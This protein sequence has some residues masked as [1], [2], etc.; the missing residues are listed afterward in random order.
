MFDRRYFALI[1]AL[2]TFRSRLPFSGSITPLKQYPFTPIFLLN[3]VSSHIV[4]FPT[5]S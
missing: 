3:P 1:N 4:D 5:E 2:E